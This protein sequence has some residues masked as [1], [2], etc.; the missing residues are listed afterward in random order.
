MWIKLVFP[1][2]YGLNFL[3]ILVKA[4]CLSILPVNIT[5]VW[6][7]FFSK[8]ICKSFL[9]NFTPFFIIN[10]YANQPE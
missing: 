4:G 7:L 1:Y 6:I 3:L 9:L 8:N 2:P 5:L 10:G